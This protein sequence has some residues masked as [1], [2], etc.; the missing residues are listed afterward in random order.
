M[1]IVL[2]ENDEN[3][4]G[5]GFANGA[6]DD[7]ITEGGRNVYCGKYKNFVCGKFF[8]SHCAVGRMLSAGKIYY[9]EKIMNKGEEVDASEGSCSGRYAE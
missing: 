5:H 9:E 2:S 1:C 6:V 3:E 4:V 8:A 7:M